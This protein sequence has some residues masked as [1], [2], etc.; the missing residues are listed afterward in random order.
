M[1]PNEYD[2]VNENDYE[3]VDYQ[4]GYEPVGGIDNQPV[5]LADGTLMDDTIPEEYHRAGEAFLH[6]E[7]PEETQLYASLPGVLND[8]IYTNP[9]NIKNIEPPPIPNKRN[10]IKQDNI[11]KQIMKLGLGYNIHRRRQ[12]GYSTRRPSL[13]RTKKYKRIL[14]NRKKT[15]TKYNIL[16]NRKHTHKVRRHTNKCRNRCNISKTRKT[17]RHN[18]T[19]RK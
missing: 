15:N 9:S 18:I 19:R 1:D 3:P 8:P 5:Y 12:G 13:L 7:Y 2:F 17:K 10:D 4:Y 6:G 11:N 14:K 16:R